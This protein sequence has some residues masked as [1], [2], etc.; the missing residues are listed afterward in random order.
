MRKIIAQLAI[1]L[2]GFIAR[3]DG[4]VDWLDRPMPR[5]GYGMS[6]FMR[7]IDTLVI[8]RETWDV[9]VKLGGGVT[10]GKENIILRVRLR[11]TRYRVRRLKAESRGN[12]R[13]DGV[14]RKAKISG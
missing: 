8:G 14:G 13:S 11:P 1:S 9:G 6:E 5:S 4:A 3:P 7:S 10:K 12:L 2:D